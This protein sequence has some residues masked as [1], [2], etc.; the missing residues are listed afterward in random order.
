MRPGRGRSDG[1]T[2]SDFEAANRKNLALLVQLRWIAVVGQIVT[3]AAAYLWLR[4]DLPLLPMAL[5]VA[6]LAALNI[7]SWVVVKT[8]RAVTARG[9]LAA[10]LIDVAAL[11]AQL[12]LSGGANNP[13]LSLYLLQVTLGAL[14][15]DAASTWAIV[16][17]ACLS[18]LGLAFSH[19]PLEVS[20]DGA[21]ALLTLRVEGLLACLILDAILLVLFVTRVVRNLRERDAHLAAMRQQVAEENHIVRMGLLASGAAHE[22][23]T[24]L[25][26][27]SVI[28]NDWWR[29]PNIGQDPQMAE[30]LEEMEAAIRR[31]KAILSGILLSAGQTRGEA[32]EA[33]TLR[34]FVEAIVWEW[35]RKHPTDPL[36]V[37]NR[38]YDAELLVASD[39]VVKQ[40]IFNVLDNA[41][42]ASPAWVQ[43]IVEQDADFLVFRVR[44]AGP[45]FPPDMLTQIG[46]PYQSSKGHPG[47]GLGLFLVVNVARKLGGS[48]SA[49]NNAGSGAEVS[50]VL[51]LASLSLEAT[52]RD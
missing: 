12:W 42:E 43:L 37:E 48:V 29:L 32:S 20:L 5:V 4:V 27:L 41:Y 21:G 18:A 39:I 13:F 28:L 50:L 47:R 40:A 10:M 19:R 8:G 52:S 1:A 31:C 33:T 3:I 16:A 17:F 38:T 11:T 7:G 26:S 9:L 23:G 35:R 46:K 25:A 15:L 30:E 49:R 36:H 2:V 6:G 14:L 34:K 51:P 24:P 44:D 45:G 22:L